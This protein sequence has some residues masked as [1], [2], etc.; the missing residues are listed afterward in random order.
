MADII[1]TSEERRLLSILNDEW[2]Q[3]HAP[4]RGI[5]DTRISDGKITEA[6][7]T[8]EI[9]L[10]GKTTG[11]VLR[12]KVSALRLLLSVKDNDLLVIA[13]GGDAS[14][15]QLAVRTRRVTDNFDMHWHPGITSLGV[16]TV[17]GKEVHLPLHSQI[18][19]CGAKG[20]G[21]SWAMRPLMA[22]A[23]CNPMYELVYIDPKMV[24]GIIWKHLIRTAIGSDEIPDTL[25]WVDGE[26]SR[27]AHLMSSKNATVWDPKTMGP[28]LIVVVDE[29]RDTLSTL[30][31][32]EKQLAKMARAASR[33]EDGMEDFDVT[34]GMLKLIRA[35]SMGRAWGVFVWWATQYPIVS[36]T[37]NP[38]ID[39]NI[40]ANADYRFSLRVAKE[41]HSRIA[42][43]TDSDYGPHLIPAGEANRG[44]GYLGGHGPNLIRTWT[45]NDDMVKN[46]DKH[47]VV[48][49]QKVQSYTPMDAARLAVR[50]GAGWSAG[51]LSRELGCTHK[52]AGLLL[53][54]MVRNGEAVRRGAEYAYK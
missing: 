45:V 12:N 6:G 5:K 39:T 20:S 52:Q 38:G 1:P 2:W 7:I 19:I 34:P 21:K 9:E 10:I 23:Y 15:V 37:N 47:P 26:L 13:P 54:A 35:S 24:E 36:N 17:T 50:H 28:Y 41:A 11:D 8:S 14:R 40:D 16:D 53:E 33:S 46:L 51:K 4:A 43:D 30:K 44:H 49:G 42:L 3:R 31:L 32:Q 27:R 29:G 18:Q 25:D 22:A 48:P